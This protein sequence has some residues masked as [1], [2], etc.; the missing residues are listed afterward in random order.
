MGRAMVWKW[1]DG[2]TDFGK[3]Q[4]EAVNKHFL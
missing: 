4:Q 2:V 3:Q 1:R